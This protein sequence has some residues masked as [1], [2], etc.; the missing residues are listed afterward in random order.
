MDE[1]AIIILD[2]KTFTESDLIFI[3][4]HIADRKDLKNYLKSGWDA[5][6]VSGNKGHARV[7]WYRDYVKSHERQ[8]ININKKGFDL[9]LRNCKT[10]SQ[11]VSVSMLLKDALNFLSKEQ[12]NELEKR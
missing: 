3:S 8:F 12:S 1:S 10:V 2:L 7:V 5:Y 4:R 11:L 9:F 6:R